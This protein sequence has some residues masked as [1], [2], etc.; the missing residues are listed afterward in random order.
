MKRLSVLALG[1][2]ITIAPACGHDE[3][4][5]IAMQFDTL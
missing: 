2:S 3:A 1:L 4:I 5:K